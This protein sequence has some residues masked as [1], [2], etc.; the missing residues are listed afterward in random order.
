MDQEKIEALRLDLIR[1][2]ERLAEANWRGDR[3]ARTIAAARVTRLRAELEVALGIQRPTTG[4]APR[5]GN[6]F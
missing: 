6:A 2:E 4:T 5:A 1:T 3:M